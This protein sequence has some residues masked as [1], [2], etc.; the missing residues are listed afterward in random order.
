METSRV[1]LI[2]FVATFDKLQRIY[3]VVTKQSFETITSSYSYNS[4]FTF[5][6]LQYAIS[7]TRPR[8]VGPDYIR[9]NVLKYM[10]WEILKMVPSFFNHLRNADHF[11]AG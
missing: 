4:D 2:N 5:Q 8:A 1:F 9:L 10:L 7:T 6:E 3:E 11:V